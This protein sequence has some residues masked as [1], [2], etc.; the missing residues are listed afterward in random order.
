MFLPHLHGTQYATSVAQCQIASKQGPHLSTADCTNRKAVLC[1]TDAQLSKGADQSNHYGS[2]Y[3][4][5][6]VADIG[7]TEQCL[8]GTALSTCLT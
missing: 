2:G 8:G 4:V 7:P 1:C 3:I 5:V 6:A